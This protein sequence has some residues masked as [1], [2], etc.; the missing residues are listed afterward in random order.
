ML[1]RF[2]S[3]LGTVLKFS[4]VFGTFPMKKYPMMTYQF[5]W[6][7]YCYSIL[8]GLI[9]CVEGTY[10][11]LVEYHYYS[12]SVTIIIE[13]I[14]FW[15]NIYNWVSVLIHSY[16]QRV[17]LPDIV[18][19]LYTIQCHI[20]ITSYKKWYA[21]SIFLLT[22]LN[23]LPSILYV[24]EDAIYFTD[25][26][27]V[28]IYFLFINVPVI[29]ASQY[30]VLMN[31]LADQLTFLTKQLSL[32]TYTFDV[33]QLVENHHALCVQAARINKS[34][35]MFL[36]QATTIPFVVIV[37][38]IYIVIVCILKPEEFDEDSKLLTS[39]MDAVVNVGIIIL[40][41]T[42]AKNAED[43]AMEFNNQLWNNMLISKTLGKDND[44]KMYVSMKYGVQQTAY[45][46]FKLNYSL[47]TSM[48][49]S[50]LTYVILLVQFTLLR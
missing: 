13:S 49:A 37:I 36:L 6:K 48:I 25:V 11:I 40:I 19:R 35:D 16:L 30:S 21:T 4:L 28:S 8:V 7:L 29:M 17:N 27:L 32:P 43:S 41:V 5:S 33:R 42:A 14:V 38:N 12:H 23:A 2:E 20:G 26:L 44:L 18:S 3:I 22:L 10:W 31:L 46:F 15:F 45:G 24:I 1:R 47:L 34:F 50:A 9:A 39:V